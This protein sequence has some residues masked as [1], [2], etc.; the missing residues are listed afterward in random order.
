MMDNY[1]WSMESW[2]ND[3][4]PVN[5]DDVIIEA[6]AIIDA[7]MAENPE[8]DEWE[9]K[10]FSGRLWEDFCETGHIGEIDAIHEDA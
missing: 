8:A 2:G 4:P 3:Y 1:F 5:A 9:V 6:N 7:Y 10:E